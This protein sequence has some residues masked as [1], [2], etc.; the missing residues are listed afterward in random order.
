MVTARSPY[1]RVMFESR[2]LRDMHK[3]G[4][5]AAYKDIVIK[6]VSAG[7]FRILMRFLYAPILPEQEG[8]GEGLVVGEMAQVADQLQTIELYVYCVE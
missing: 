2:S 1:F 8:C 6:D 5:C 7:A 3:E 4:S